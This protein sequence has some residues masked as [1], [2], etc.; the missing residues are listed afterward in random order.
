MWDGLD[1]VLAA[2]SVLSPTGRRS[3]GGKR[4]AVPMTG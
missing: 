1:A 4:W 2:E 3:N